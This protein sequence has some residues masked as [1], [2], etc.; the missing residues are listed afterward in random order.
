MLFRSTVAA[1]T[2]LTDANIIINAVS[3]DRLSDVTIGAIST[4]TGTH[5]SVTNVVIKSSGSRIAPA[6]ISVKGSITLDNTYGGGTPTSL[7]LN[8]TNIASTNTT[9]AG[10]AVDVSG[11]LVAGTGITIRGATYTY[12]GFATSSSVSTRSEEHTSE[13]QSH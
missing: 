5:T 10:H 12:W 6:G 7:Y 11:A 9:A 4:S 3:G 1:N 13:L 2:T 8:S